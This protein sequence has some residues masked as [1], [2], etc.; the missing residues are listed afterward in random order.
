MLV[1]ACETITLTPSIVSTL[2]IRP[3]WVPPCWS[4]VWLLVLYFKIYGIC[5]V[6]IS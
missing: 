6:Y 5:I 1:L 3:S 4:V 2:R